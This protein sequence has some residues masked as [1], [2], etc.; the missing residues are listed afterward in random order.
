VH[1]D[2]WPDD[3]RHWRSRMRT[4]PNLLDGEISMVTIIL[5]E[6]DID[7]QNSYKIYPYTLTAS[8]QVTKVK[9][10]VA[11]T[12]VLALVSMTKC[13]HCS[14]ASKSASWPWPDDLY[15]IWRSQK[16]GPSSNSRAPCLFI[17]CLC[18]LLGLLPLCW[19]IKIIN[20]FGQMRKTLISNYIVYQ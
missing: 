1:H 19:W 6:V 8:F 7:F 13:H 16:G 9:S 15:G 10:S 2:L 12:V 11:S 18:P 5:M 20:I 4:S 3:F 17:A 14:L